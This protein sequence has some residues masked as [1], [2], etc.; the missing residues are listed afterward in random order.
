MFD[1]RG[2]AFTVSILSFLAG[3]YLR[4]F[5]V[6]DFFFA[7]SILVAS[8]LL[9]LFA[10]RLSSSKRIWCVCASIILLASS[11]GIIRYEL[12]EHVSD[13]ISPY[14][15]TPVTAEGVVVGE[16]D[17]RETSTLLVVRVESLSVSAD[18]IPLSE[19]VLVVAPQF[20]RYEYGDRIRLSGKIQ[21]PENFTTDT[22]REFDYRHISQKTE[23]N[24]RCFRRR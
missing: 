10:S 12:S 23:Y 15:S 20:P 21:L 22:G 13:A 11:A 14:L 1:M 16:P 8:A 9:L 18:K 5:V 2:K 4:S 19:K 3:V 17:L 24:M 6:I 7:L